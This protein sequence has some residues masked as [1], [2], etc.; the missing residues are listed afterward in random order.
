MCS[1]V[2]LRSDQIV[3][4]EVGLIANFIEA[5]EITACTVE[6]SPTVS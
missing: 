6:I 2:A 4:G 3:C 5:A 1:L